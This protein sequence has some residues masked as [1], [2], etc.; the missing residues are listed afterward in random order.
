M[1]KRQQI[2]PEGVRILASRGYGA[3]TMRA[4]ARASR[5]KPGALQYPFRTREDLLRGPAPYVA[6][7]H[8]TAF[9]APH[10]EPARPSLPSAVASRPE[11]GP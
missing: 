5:I 9:A 1:Y 7:P 2:L 6:D 4:V 10:S 8:R 3:L 11:G